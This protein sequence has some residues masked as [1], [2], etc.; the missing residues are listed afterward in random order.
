MK[1]TRRLSR[2]ARIVVKVAWGLLDRKHPLLVHVIAMRR[3]NLACGYCNEYDAVS[4]PV[5]AGIVKG[6]I[7]RLATLGTATITF[8]GGEPLMHPEL[9]ELIA[10]ARGRG[11]VV[12]LITNGYYLSP[13]R[14]QRL[15][16]AGLD[17][18]Q[19]SIDNVEPDDVS[20][21]S[22]RLLEPK[23]RWL[24]D[25]AWFSVAINSVL[26]SGVRNPK[27]ALAVARRAREL[28]FMS[29]LGII[30]DG[31]GQLRALSPGEMDV[32]EELRRLGRWGALSFNYRFQDNLA[33]G[34][35]N[36][37]SCRAGAR[38]LYVDENGLVHYCSQQRG[39]PGIPLESY[40]PADIRREY[41][42]KKDCAPFCTVNCVQQVALL[43]NWRAP[44][45]LTAELPVAGGK[46][47]PVVDE[48]ALA[49]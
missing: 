44:Q 1:W 45:R 14:I 7:D 2:A 25:H 49:G 15:N 39:M 28:G 6:R 46:Q 3:C 19:I 36:A 40:G 4:R 33:R 26:G 48:T 10:H 20:K 5:P 34:R 9:D 35:P 13:E 29:S 38:Y 27:D 22:L 31:R 8:S 30:H 23:L 32:Y 16:R 47:S 37:W 24:A 17:H 21:K 11:M 43:D 41:Y 12:T 42:T 18:L